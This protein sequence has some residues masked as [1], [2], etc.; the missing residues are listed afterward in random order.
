MEISKL[1]TEKEEIQTENQQLNSENSRLTDLFKVWNKSSVSRTE[2]QELKILVT[3]KTCLGF[4]SLGE[5]SETGTKPKLEMCKEKYIYFVK[6]SLVLEQNELIKHVAEPAENMNN[7]N[8]F[9][10]EYTPESS[11][12][13]H[14]WSS[15]RFSSAR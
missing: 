2:M 7:G 9:G 12:V 1:K 3:D 13:K 15:N 5:T 11:N 6:S 4:N 8:K 14:N 10:I